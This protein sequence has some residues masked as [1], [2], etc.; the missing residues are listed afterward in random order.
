MTLTD[1][2]INFIYTLNS[3]Y[4]MHMNDSWRCDFCESGCDCDE[5][6]AKSLLDDYSEKFATTDNLPIVEDMI[7]NY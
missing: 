4:R 3:R 6:Y 7:R 2:H 1:E 5:S